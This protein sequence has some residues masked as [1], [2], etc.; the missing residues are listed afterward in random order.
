MK[1]YGGGG[2]MSA[3]TSGDG[4]RSHTREKLYYRHESK[5]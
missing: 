5:H 4:T 3:W 2:E 1:G